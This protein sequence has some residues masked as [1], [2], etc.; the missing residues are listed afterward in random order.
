LL[1]EA[2]PTEIRKLFHSL[3]ELRHALCPFFSYRYED[4]TV[5]LWDC[6]QP[7]EPVALIVRAHSEP[8]MSV[9]VDSAAEGKL[10]PPKMH[11]IIKPTDTPP[12]KSG[13][14]QS[15]TGIVVRSVG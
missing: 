13:H 9:A 4:G 10:P 11:T 1:I 14:F 15:T 2:R 12:Q 3:F 8:V 7:T 5:A 6:A